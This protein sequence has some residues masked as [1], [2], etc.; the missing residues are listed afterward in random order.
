M[1]KVNFLKP[2]LKTIKRLH[3]F[4]VTVVLPQVMFL[5]TGVKAWNQLPTSVRHINCVAT[6]KRQVRRTVYHRYIIFH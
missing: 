2:K 1:Y 6:F 5:Y 4:E 3:S